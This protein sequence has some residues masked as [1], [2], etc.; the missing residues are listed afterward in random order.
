[1]ND[2]DAK[3]ASFVEGCNKMYNDYMDK[4]FPNNPR[5]M[6]AVVGGRKYIKVAKC[7]LD[8]KPH[9]AYCFVDKTNGNVLKAAG[10]NA[11]AKGA[12]GNIFKEDNGLS[13]VTPYGGVYLR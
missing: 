5:E 8:G 13:G 11:P 3:L 7:G 1:M 9:S 10:W 12:R 6:I 2:F 4:E